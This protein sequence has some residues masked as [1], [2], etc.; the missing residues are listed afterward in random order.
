MMDNEATIPSSL[1]STEAENVDTETGNSDKSLSHIN[2]SSNSPETTSNQLQSNN[3][4]RSST[5]TVSVPSLESVPI[6]QLRTRIANAE[7]VNYPFKTLNRILD[8]LKWTIPVQEK[9]NFSML[10][11]KPIDYSE[12]LSKVVNS[13]VTHFETLILNN[14]LEYC[15][16]VEKVEYSNSQQVLYI[17][18]GI[19]LDKKHGTYHFRLAALETDSNPFV[20][21]LIDKHQYHVIPK[22]SISAHDLQILLE[23]TID[24]DKIIDDAFFKSLNSPNGQILRVTLFKA[25]F[26]QEDL[27]PLT[28]EEIIRERYLEGIKRHPNL[29]PE[30]IPNQLHC[31][32]TLIKV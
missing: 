24:V 20:T 2:R 19:L 9:Y 11:S 21:K 25:E 27:V 30:T 17:M 8:D 13:S 7:L 31:I 1:A 3:P 28:D 26:T 6:S 18:R 29:S 12:E 4:F 14:D 22:S 23:N 16:S 10:N 5:L 15:K 32:K